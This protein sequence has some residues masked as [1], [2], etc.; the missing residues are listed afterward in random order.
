[1]ANLLKD[2][3]TGSIG[4]VVP[5]NNGKNGKNNGGNAGGAATCKD[6]GRMRQVLLSLAMQEKW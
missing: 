1:M 2:P 6:V 4:Q 5:A 3:V